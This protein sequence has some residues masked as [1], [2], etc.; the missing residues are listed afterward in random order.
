MS[1]IKQYSIFSELHST[2]VGFICSNVFIYTILI[3]MDTAIIAGL[4]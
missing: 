4:R 2:Y 3:S 1:Y